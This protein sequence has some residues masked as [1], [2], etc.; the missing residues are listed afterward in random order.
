MKTE[1][2]VNKKKRKVSKR[3]KKSWIKHVN[4]KDVEDFL[5]YKRLEERLG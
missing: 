2:E 5:D 3:N 1:T 4:N